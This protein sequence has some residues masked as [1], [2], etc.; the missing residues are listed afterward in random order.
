[1]SQKVSSNHFF[2]EIFSWFFWHLKVI[3]ISVSSSKVLHGLLHHEGIGI[4]AG[5]F[6]S[7]RCL[8]V[9]PIALL[10]TL[11]SPKVYQNMPF[12]IHKKQNS[13]Y[14]EGC[15]SRPM[16]SCTWQKVQSATCEMVEWL[17]PS[18][19]LK[20]VKLHFRN[21]SLLLASSRWVDQ[22]WCSAATIALF[23]NTAASSV[24]AAIRIE[25]LKNLKFATR[26][27]SFFSL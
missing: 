17:V 10:T 7:T 15:C 19:D 5:C 3:T 27:Q 11:L 22:W 24:A 16:S 20:L 9:S 26:N 18:L 1:M 12:T 25:F 23:T 13:A 14:V 6:W 4:S 21:Q 8:F 2:Q